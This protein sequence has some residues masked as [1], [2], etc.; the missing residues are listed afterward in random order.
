[1]R[2]NETETTALNGG[3]VTYDIGI[4]PRIYLG[5][6]LAAQPKIQSLND[7]F[8]VPYEDSRQNPNI[9]T[10]IQKQ[11]LEQNKSVYIA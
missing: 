4:H 8:G 5:I 9:Q 7:L 10:P 2:V 1:M 11:K 6:S 3:V